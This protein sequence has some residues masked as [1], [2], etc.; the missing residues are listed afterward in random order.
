[1]SLF[2][3]NIITEE[4]LKSKRFD[5]LNT[6]GFYKRTHRRKNLFSLYELIYYPEAT[7]KYP[8]GGTLEV[9]ELVHNYNLLGVGMSK[10]VSKEVYFNILDQIDFESTLHKLELL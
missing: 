8:V 6:G 3:E 7:D 1:M 5:K 10:E 4:Y 2:D 9:I